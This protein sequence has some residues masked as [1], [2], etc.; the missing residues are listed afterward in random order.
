MN[1]EEKIERTGRRGR[2]GKKLLD[3]REEKIRWWKF[4]EEALCL[5]LSRI[6]LRKPV[7]R[8]NDPAADGDD[9]DDDGDDDDDDDDHDDDNNKED[10]CTS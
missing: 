7:V 1:L 8:G 4:K 3:D 5:T 2:R 9:D 6:R 10:S